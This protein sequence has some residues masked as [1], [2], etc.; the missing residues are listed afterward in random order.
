[1]TRRLSRRSTR[2]DS[3]NCSW[4]HFCSFKSFSRSQ[5]SSFFLSFSFS[6]S[7]FLQSIPLSEVAP[8]FFQVVFERF[9]S[10]WRKKRLRSWPGATWENRRRGRNKGKRGSVGAGVSLVERANFLTTGRG[11]WRRKRKKGARKKE[12]LWRKNIC[13]S[14]ILS[15]IIMMPFFFFSFSVFFFP[16]FFLSYTHQVPSPVSLSFRIHT[17]ANP[18]GSHVAQ[19]VEG[20][21]DQERTG[22]GAAWQW[23]EEERERGREVWEEERESEEQKR[24]RGERLRSVYKD[25]STGQWEWER[26]RGHK[27]RKRS[28][29]TTE[30]ILLERR[31]DHFSQNLWQWLKS[32]KVMKHFHSLHRIINF[33]LMRRLILNHTCL[34]DCINDTPCVSCGLKVKTKKLNSDSSLSRDSNPTTSCQVYMECS[35][36]RRR[37]VPCEKNTDWEKGNPENR[38][39]MRKTWK[40]RIRSSWMITIMT[41]DF[42]WITS[43]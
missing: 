43:S 14:W 36:V 9:F 24:E 29:G 11:T 1:M 32:I 22:K 41:Q 18:W 39:V 19:A 27:K 37:N 5:P 25:C 35:V 20:E 26:E 38:N 7:F 8:D 21:N 3:Q 34:T 16:S 23:G 13:L 17:H 42:N 28:L 40:W 33:F 6:V 2:K 15:L 30:G 12:N 10:Y 4:T 31:N